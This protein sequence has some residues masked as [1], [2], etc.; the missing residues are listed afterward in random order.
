MLGRLTL[1]SIVSKA[2]KL[3]KA[4]LKWTDERIKLVNE[5]MMA[6]QVVKVDR[7][8]PRCTDQHQVLCMGT[9]STGTRPKLAEAGAP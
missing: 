3:L 6:M 9:R 4:S 2:S 1:I 8:C 7:L 5:I